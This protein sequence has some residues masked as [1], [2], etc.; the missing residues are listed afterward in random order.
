MTNSSHIIIIKIAWSTFKVSTNFKLTFRSEL[1]QFL[2]LVWYIIWCIIC[3]TIK[4]TF[5]HYLIFRKW[6]SLCLHSSSFIFIVSQ[7]TW[8]S[9]K[10]PTSFKLTDRSKLCLLLTLPTDIILM[11]VCI[12]IK[13]SFRHN[14]ILGQLQFLCFLSLSSIEIIFN[15]TRISIKGIFT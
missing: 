8:N 6:Y 7:I 14:E 1:L 12:S 2:C 4:S 3:R 5:R 15:I 11:I 10:C 9:I 13:F